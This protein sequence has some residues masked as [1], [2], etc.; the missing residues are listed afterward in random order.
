MSLVLVNSRANE[1]GTRQLCGVVREFFGIETSPLEENHSRDVNNYDFI[2]VIRRRNQSIRILGNG[3]SNSNEYIVLLYYDMPSYSRTLSS[4]FSIFPKYHHRCIIKCWG[5]RVLFCF[6]LWLKKK[7][8]VN[9][10]LSIYDKNANLVESK[11]KF[12]T[13]FGEVFARVSNNCF[14]ISSTYASM[15][16]FIEIP[17]PMVAVSCGCFSRSRVHKSK[18]Y[19]FFACTFIHSEYDDVCC[20][21]IRMA[22]AF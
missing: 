4:H 22:I 6:C 14:P 7:L 2:R 10:S 5:T 19:Y 16:K 15:A 12:G 3:K 11:T 9:I 1:M 13:F 21:I 8:I 20:D 17:A 18:A